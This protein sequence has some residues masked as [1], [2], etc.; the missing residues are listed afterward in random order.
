MSVQASARRRVTS[1][2]I[3]L[4]VPLTVACIALLLGAAPAAAAGPLPPQV[5]I[6]FGPS[7][8]RTGQD[9]NFFAAATA[10]SGTITTYDWDFGDGT[11]HSSNPAPTHSFA[12]AGDQTVKLTVKDSNL[13]TTSEWVLV[14][15]HSA[16]LNL[17]PT[18]TNVQ[19]TNADAEPVNPRAGVPV[20]LFSDASD[21][22]ADTLT[23]DWSFGDGTAHS[24]DPNPDHTFNNAGNFLVTVTVSDP[25]GKTASQAVAVQVHGTNRPPIITDVGSVDPNPD[26][27]TGVDMF[28][29][30]TDDAT[31]AGDFTYTWDFG[32]GT[33]STASAP[34]HTYAAPGF[35]TVKVT[36]DDGDG[37]DSHAS[38][39]QAVGQPNRPSAFFETDYDHSSSGINA[40][41]VRP[42][43]AVSF[44]DESTPV[45]GTTI[46]SFS[47]DFGDGGT[48][49]DQNP[50]HTFPLTPGQHYTVVETVTDAAGRHDKYSETITVSNMPLAP[51]VSI[52]MFPV[53]PRTGQTVSFTS[54]VYDPDN[55]PTQAN[56]SDTHVTY[57]WNFGDGTAHSPLANPQHTY[58][59]D[60]SKT[61]IL[62]VTDTDDGLSTQSARVLVVHA[63]DIPPTPSFSPF[64]ILA[65][66]GEV[67]T[68][69]NVTSD[70]DDPA[71]TLT[72]DWNFGDGTAHSS[73]ASPTHAYASPGD[74]FV[75]L[76]ADDGHPGGAAT[77][78][79]TV[80][81]LL[82]KAPAKLTDPTIS[83]TPQ[84][85]QTLTEEDGTFSGSPANHAHQWQRCD[86]SGGTCE[87]IVGETG[88]TYLLASTDVGHTIRVVDTATN[89]GGSDSG[90]SDPTDIVIVA[91]PA[92]STPPSISGT[93]VVGQPLTADP[94][95]WTGSPTFAL[96]WQR[97]DATGGSCVDVGSAN[98]S[99]YTLTSADQGH[100]LRVRV[101]AT[102]D[103]GTV[104]ATSAQSG[105][106]TVAVVAPAKTSDP[107]ITGTAAIGQQLTV[108]PATFTGSAATVTH[109]WQSCDASGGNCIAIGGATGATYIVT[110]A[111]VGHT[112]RVVDTATNGAGTASGTSAATAVVPAPAAAPTVTTGPSI[113]GTTTVGQQLTANAG[114]W[115]GSP[116]FAYQWQQCDGSGGSCVDISGALGTTYT[117]A[118][119][120]QGHTIRVK[121]TAT[122]GVGSVTATSAQT[123]AIA[124]ASSGGGG[125]GGGGGGSGGGLTAAQIRAKMVG[126][127]APKGSAAKIGELL[128]KSGYNLSFTA[129]V[130]GTVTIRWYHLPAGSRLLASTGAKPKPILVASGKR[131]YSK[132]GKATIKV[133]LTAAAR[134]LMRKAKSLKITGTA[135]LTRSGKPKVT[136]TKAFTLKR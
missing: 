19:V 126:Q 60:G 48:S 125:G 128:K 102:N 115:T 70:K 132:A 96:Q 82:D 26:P 37:G 63:D 25:G 23:Y 21:P 111:D 2:R 4:F 107:A 51:E 50:T 47:W 86:A 77:E 72:Y 7:A 97:C 15:V 36:V 44:H 11:A 68:F 12:S 101:T 45:E 59:T 81:V 90:T 3:R 17:P 8:P 124:A 130:A 30:A 75:T 120:D 129:P 1:A 62:T 134:K 133:K 123:A 94:G 91:A 52:D 108:T 69:T 71:N 89:N 131:P 118:S 112:I 46:T 5:V 67:V 10:S 110:A 18:V 103:G 41:S 109:Q 43:T 16:S 40:G 65:G 127:I 29:G 54:T 24:T 135:T 76:K 122:N 35:Y 34:T 14:H 64:P 114:T 85:G 27:G 98:G 99:M 20:S 6:A 79:V 84:A 78:G 100:T 55:P 106:V 42:G 119:G 61:A 56:P 105:V 9:V 38:F 136:A 117:L 104:S 66:T 39:V 88:T 95:A 92:V 28:V 121:V 31:L 87:N 113:S 53:A 57:D 74:Y 13:L 73:L 33:Q 83:G 22:E 93:T 49:N 80:H 32:D 58:S 116:S